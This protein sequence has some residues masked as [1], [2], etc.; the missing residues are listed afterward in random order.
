MALDN[1]DGQSFAKAF[2]TDK[3]CFSGVEFEKSEIASS[4]GT[5]I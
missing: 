4:F 1:P 5:E 2:A 3:I